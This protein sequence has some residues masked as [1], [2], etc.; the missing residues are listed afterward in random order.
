MCKFDNQHIVEELKNKLGFGWHVYPVNIYQKSGK[1][2]N[3]PIAYRG[4][5]YC[6][7]C[8]SGNISELHYATY[9]IVSGGSKE[10]VFQCDD[11]YKFM[12]VEHE[13]G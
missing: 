10:W 1:S 9:G 8:R 11:C 13:W 7:H 5:L 4:P 2:F 6:V 3:K 12:S